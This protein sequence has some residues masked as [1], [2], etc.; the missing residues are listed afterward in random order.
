[1]IVAK[2]F[3]LSL[4]LTSGWYEAFLINLWGCTSYLSKDA[5]DSVCGEQFRLVQKIQI[6]HKNLTISFD[7]NNR[8]LRFWQR[9]LSEKSCLWREKWQI[10]SNGNMSNEQCYKR[11]GQFLASLVCSPPFLSG[12]IRHNKEKKLEKKKK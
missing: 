9:K 12:I 6:E 7:G 10:W 8:K 3:N 1:M 5:T 4:G 11:W 2:N